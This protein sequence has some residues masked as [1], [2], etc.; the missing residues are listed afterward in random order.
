MNYS[1][2]ELIQKY[3]ASGYILGNLFQIMQKYAWLRKDAIYQ[4]TVTAWEE[5]ILFFFS[6]S[7]T[8]VKIAN[9]IL[10]SFWL[11]Q[12]MSNKQ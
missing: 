1:M 7:S 11:R 6:M 5:S 9:V 3:L 8:V 12:R 4:I 10:N 2:L